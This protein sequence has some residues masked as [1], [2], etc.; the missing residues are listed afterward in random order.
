VQV[1]ERV[2]VEHFNDAVQ[3]CVVGGIGEEKVP[4]FVG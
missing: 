1:R 2:D 3:G 4:V